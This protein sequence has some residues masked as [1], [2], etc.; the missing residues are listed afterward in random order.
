M[1]FKEE[2]GTKLIDLFFAGDVCIHF[3]R[4]EVSNPICNNTFFIIKGKF[5]DKADDVVEVERFATVD[6]DLAFSV[7]KVWCESTER[8]QLKE[9]E[10]RIKMLKAME[11]IARCTN[12]EELFYIWL[13]AGVPDGE[14]KYGDLSLSNNDLRLTDYTDNKTFAEIMHAFLKLM[15]RIYEEETGLY[16]DNVLSRNYEND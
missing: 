6:R 1:K 12:D 8:T 15:H 14:I 3:S 7:F 4:N 10:K 9:N 11:Y 5:D 16:C 2:P 13:Y